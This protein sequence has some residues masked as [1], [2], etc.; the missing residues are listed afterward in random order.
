MKRVEEIKSLV[1]KADSSYL[2]M[3]EQFKIS[4]HESLIQHL[5]LVVKNGGEGLMLHRMHSFYE[6]RQL[7]RPIFTTY[8]YLRFNADMLLRWC[9]KVP[10]RVMGWPR[11]WAKWYRRWERKRQ[12]AI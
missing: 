6:L 5:N 2:Q 10:Q 12:G 9:I 11:K 4:D 3:V 8:D 1:L 7:S